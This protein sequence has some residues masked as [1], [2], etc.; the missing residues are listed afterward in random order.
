M[1][2]D[3]RVDGK[4]QRVFVLTESKDRIVYIPLKNLTKIHYDQLTKI[5][6]ANP[7]NMLEEMRKSTLSNGRNALVMFESVIQVFEKVESDKEGTRLPKP[8]EAINK[9]ETQSQVKQAE[10]PKPVIAEE[11]PTAR[12]KPGPKPKQ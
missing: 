3:I 8:E 4:L 2:K 5:S 10:P 7:N 1:K 6:E 11:Q 9:V 12:R